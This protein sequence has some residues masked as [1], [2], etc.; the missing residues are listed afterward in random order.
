MLGRC[1]TADFEHLHR[2]DLLGE[3]IARLASAKI[4]FGKEFF[5]L[6]GEILLLGKLDF[7]TLDHL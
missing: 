3:K 1:K 7:S 4:N 6:L 2:A 5:F